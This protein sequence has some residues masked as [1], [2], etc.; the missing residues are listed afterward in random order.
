VFSEISS[1]RFVWGRDIRDSPSYNI[2]YTGA[3]IS[4]I[5]SISS[6]REILMSRDIQKSV[7]ALHSNTV[8][9][10]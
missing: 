10:I 9:T 4:F 3:D 8:P 6:S 1:R 7:Y 2:N 5:Q